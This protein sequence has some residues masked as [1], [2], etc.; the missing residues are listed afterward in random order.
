MALCS[1]TQH[2]GDWQCT[3]CGRVYR[4]NVL[5]ECAANPTVLPSVTVCRHLGAAV[6]TI[7]VPCGCAAGTRVT[8]AA[9]ACD[10]HRRCVPHWTPPDA[11]AWREQ[12]EAA[13][14]HV[15]AGCES[16]AAN[17]S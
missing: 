3:A 9:F 13:L 16:F 4:L 8:L 5:A 2:G 11:A 7:K 12:P 15:C 17:S 1:L 6:G 10:V 14:Y